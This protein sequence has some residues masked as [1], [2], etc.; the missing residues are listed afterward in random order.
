MSRVL[1][2][3]LGGRRIGLALSDPL[4][5]TAFGVDGIR[6]TGEGDVIRSLRERVRE[7]EVT[8][9]VVG[10]P[11]QMDGSRG[12]EAEAVLRF[13]E[14][15]EEALGLPVQT[16]D[17]RL[18]S[19]QADRILAEAKVRGEKRKRLQDRVAAQIILQAYLNHLGASG[20]D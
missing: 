10:L 4:G 3:D 11:I 19:V 12:P 9:V 6:N 13:C 18:T 5:H 7:H 8:R 14:K 16:W 20:S 15:L 17:E 2:I 1:G